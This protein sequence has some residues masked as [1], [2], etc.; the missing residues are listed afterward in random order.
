MAAIIHETGKDDGA[1][2]EKESPGH[3]PGVFQSFG[4]H[5]VR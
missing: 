5:L 4:F 1:I 3:Q 2:E